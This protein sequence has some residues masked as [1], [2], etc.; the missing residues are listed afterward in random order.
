MKTS[1]DSTVFHDTETVPDA[2]WKLFTCPEDQ[3]HWCDIYEH[4]RENAAVVAAVEQYRKTKIWPRPDMFINA[5]HQF[6]ACRFFDAFPEFPARPFL[7]IPNHERHT[8]CASLD[9][10][11]DGMKARHHSPMTQ[12]VAPDGMRLLEISENITREE[13]DRLWKHYPQKKGK[14][15]LSADRIRDLSALRLYNFV[16]TWDAVA[17]HL[18]AMLIRLFA[19]NTDQLGRTGSRAAKDTSTVLRRIL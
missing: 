15:R 16:G 12:V 2:E 14:K 13:W 19:K 9:M 6:V 3:T 7:S 18:D 1:K 4:A 10:E 17:D 5:C 8:K 11:R